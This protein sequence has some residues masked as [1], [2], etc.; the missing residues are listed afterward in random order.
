MALWLGTVIEKGQLAYSRSGCELT[1]EIWSWILPEGKRV[2]GE[3][4]FS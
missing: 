2:L 1:G 3:I 4:S